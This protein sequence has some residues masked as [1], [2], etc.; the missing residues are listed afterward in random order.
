M[1]LTLQAE[2][3][4]HLSGLLQR[5]Q[6]G[7]RAAYEQFLLETRVVLR[8]FFQGRAGGSQHLDDLVQETL[9]AIH[10]Y[11]HTYDPRRRIYPWI[12]AIARHRLTDLARTQRRQENHELAYGRDWESQHAAHDGDRLSQAD[13]VQRALEALSAAQREVIWLLKFE[14]HSV[15]EVA[16]KTGRS[17]A[18]VKVAAH[19]GYEVL[20]RLLRGSGNHD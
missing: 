12:I 19:R 18:S 15:A 9:I 8:R 14:G 2:I 5:A 6:E 16:A 1:W 20:R 3:D 17:A 11:R 4:R 7:D 13:F 10:R